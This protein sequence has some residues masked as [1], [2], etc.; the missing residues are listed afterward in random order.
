MRYINEII[1]HCSDTPPSHNWGVKEIRACHLQ[2]GFTDAGYHYIIK[3]NGEIERGR[4]L[5]RIGAHC[6]GHNAHSIGICYIGGQNSEGKRTDTRTKAQKESLLKL[7]TKLTI[8][9]RCKT[10]GHHDYDINKLC[11]CFDA[12]NEYSN[13]LKQIIKKNIPKPIATNV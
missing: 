10:A 5:Y 3:Q 2:R 13:I 7:I 12:K 4:P 8:L 11:P 6:R 9:Y 1:I